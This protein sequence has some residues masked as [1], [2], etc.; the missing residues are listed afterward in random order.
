MQRW[1][2]KRQTTSIQE[3]LIQGRRQM[4]SSHNKHKDFALK[5]SLLFFYSL[6]TIDRFTTALNVDAESA[7]AKSRQDEGGKKVPQRRHWQ[8]RYWWSTDH[9]ADVT[10]RIIIKKHGCQRGWGR[11]DQFN[12]GFSE[13]SLHLLRSSYFI[14]TLRRHFL[15]LIFIQV[16]QQASISTSKKCNFFFPPNFCLEFPWFLCG[17]WRSLNTSYKTC[18]SQKWK[19]GWTV[20]A[21]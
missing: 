15:T 17:L 5:K 19:R 11:I 3:V 9:R 13:W 14:F 10:Q 18:K 2:K 21:L 4:R 1:R 20:S 16:E 8:S 6:M 7:T 12:K